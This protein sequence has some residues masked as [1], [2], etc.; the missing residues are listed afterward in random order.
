MPFPIYFTTKTKDPK[1]M[2][3]SPENLALGETRSYHLEAELIS[4]KGL[5]QC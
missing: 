1:D 5:T 3:I 4:D 2:R